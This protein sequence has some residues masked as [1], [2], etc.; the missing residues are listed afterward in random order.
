M[1]PQTIGGV[2]ILAPVRPEYRAILS[3]QAMDFVASLAR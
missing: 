1:K 3:P 2:T